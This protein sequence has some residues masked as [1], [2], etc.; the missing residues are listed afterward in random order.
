MT[1]RLPLWAGPDSGLHRTQ[2][3]PSEFRCCSDR[4]DP[5]SS[6]G[7]ACIGVCTTFVHHLSA[8]KHDHSLYMGPP[9]ICL[10]AHV[11]W[12]G[13]DQT[14]CACVANFVVY[15]CSHSVQVWRVRLPIWAGPDSAMSDDESCC[16]APS[17]VNSDDDDLVSE[18]GYVAVRGCSTMTTWSVSEVF[19]VSRADDE[20]SDESVSPPWI[21]F[22]AC[23]WASF[24]HRLLLRQELRDKH[25]MMRRSQKC[26]KLTWM[27]QELRQEL[28]GCPRHGI[29]VTQFCPGHGKGHIDQTFVDT[30]M[31]RRPITRWHYGRLLWALA[32]GRHPLSKTDRK[33]LYLNGRNTNFPY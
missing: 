6:Q 33:K 28:H 31:G 11:G 10:S 7:D 23:E 24:A 13:P 19:I 29:C 12:T 26:S 14:V 1:V 30:V 21:L 22:A 18:S 4:A 20:D 25:Y 27:R 17:L 2:E 16:S 3:M 32:T 9:I 8:K 5:F 15:S